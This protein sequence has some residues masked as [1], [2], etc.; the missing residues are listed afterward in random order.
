MSTM[1][2]Q[3]NSIEVINLRLKFPGEAALVFKDVSFSVS[4]G[5]KVLLLGPSGCGK[6]TL[7]QVMSG[8]IPNS[9]DVPLSH[10]AIQLPDSWGF[11]FQDPD[12]QFCMPY[13]DEE[14]AFVLENLG[15]AREEMPERI[16]RYL[17]STGLEFE[18]SHQPISTL[19]RGQ[20]QRLAL[21]SALALEPD[22][23][24]LDEPTALLDPG[25][26]KNIWQ[27]VRRISRDKTLLIVEHKIDKV[28]GFMDRMVVL[29][30][31]GKL[32]IDGPASTI[33]QHRSLLDRYGIWHAQSWNA[34]DE[35]CAPSLPLPKINTEMA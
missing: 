6:S 13:V 10:D 25:G 16:I 34:F 7:L 20:K 19:S 23:L 11:V 31:R 12:A 3:Q 1:T 17:D 18:D 15:V 4:P 26:T 35:Q 27:H 32:I 24:V 8:I 22:T 28:I 14:I 33:Q 5:E 21:A 2:D 9:F 29:D 30:E